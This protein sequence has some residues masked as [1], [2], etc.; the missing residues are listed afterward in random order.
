VNAPN[1]DTRENVAKAIFRAYKSGC[2]GFTYYRDGSRTEQVVTFS[3][4]G[5]LKDGN[6]DVTGAA[7]A[8]TVRDDDDELTALLAH[9]AEL[10]NRN[11]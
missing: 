11:G 7:P 6:R 3:K 4:D 1:D 8:E 2:K 5:D 9:A 10:V